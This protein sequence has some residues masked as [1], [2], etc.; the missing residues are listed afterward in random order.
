M[1]KNEIKKSFDNRVY[2]LQCKTN[3]FIHLCFSGRNLRPI[4]EHLSPEATINIKKNYFFWFIYTR[5]DSPTLVYI[6][7]QIV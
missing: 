2:L 7:L 1:D 3:S 4:K 6:G 5:L